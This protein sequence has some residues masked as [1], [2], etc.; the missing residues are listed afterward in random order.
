MPV[1]GTPFR[2]IRDTAEF[3]IGQ[4]GAILRMGKS[5]GLLLPQVAADHQ[6]TAEDFWRALA[7]KSLLAPNDWRDPRARLDIFGAQI[8]ERHQ[9]A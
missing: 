9:A 3:R 8:F 5:C 2:R 4:H 6:W 1:E 7:R